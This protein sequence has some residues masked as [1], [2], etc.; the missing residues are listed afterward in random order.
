MLIVGWSVGCSSY[1][2]GERAS[3]GGMRLR[4]GKFFFL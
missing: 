3:I 2:W 4:G 1:G